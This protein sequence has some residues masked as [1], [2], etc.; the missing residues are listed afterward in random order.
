MISKYKGL[1]VEFINES[2][3]ELG[4]TDNI[5]IYDAIYSDGNYNYQTKHGINVSEN[6]KKVSSALLVGNGGGI[7]VHENSF[8]I[9]NDDIFI[10][11]SEM[12]YS[13][14]LPKLTLNWY[15]AI[16]QA[17]NFEIYTFKDDFIIH[18]EM[19]I[20][21]ITAN[22]EIKWE[23]SARD[24]FVNLNSHKEFEIIGEQIKLVDF[25]NY[26]YIIDENG[27]VISD[28]LLK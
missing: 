28:R 4:S 9:K 2:N 23:F 22:S 1:V 8:V 21:R 26:E 18:G 11:C 7:T 3:Y 20:F 6:D 27:N 10:C 25:Q 14:K 15:K 17:T 13:L 12:V 19:S 16:D 24:I 5:N